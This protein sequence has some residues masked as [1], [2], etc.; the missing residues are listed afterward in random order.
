M[1]KDLTGRKFGSLSVVEL[2]QPDENNDRKWICKCD[3]GN[4]THVYGYS[5]NHGHYKSCGCQHAA[6]RDAGL[7]QHINADTTF[8]TRKS[9]L[10]SKLH[11]KNKSG[12]KGVRWVEARRKWQANIGYQGRQ[13]NLGYFND[14]E[15]AI[16]ARKA[17][18]EKYHK[19]HLEDDV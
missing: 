7:K 18:E 6:K 13:I 19:P 4:I 17:A 3:C 2:A 8:G 1:R 14:K 10:T 11:K 5:L 16:I 9:A 12:H 15:S